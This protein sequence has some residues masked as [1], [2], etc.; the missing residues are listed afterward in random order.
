[1]GNY[2]CFFSPLFIYLFCFLFLEYITCI[3]MDIHYTRKQKKEERK[4][5]TNSVIGSLV[6]RAIHDF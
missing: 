3:W 6:L 5:E 2:F 4:G 1:M